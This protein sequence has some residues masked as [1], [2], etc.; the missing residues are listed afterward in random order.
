VAKPSK[1]TEGATLEAVLSRSKPQIERERGRERQKERERERESHRSRGRG[2]ERQRETG[3][4][5][6]GGRK[7]KDPKV[8]KPS[9]RTEG[10]TLEAV[11]SRSKPQT[12]FCHGPNPKSL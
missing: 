10:A 3:I 4:E 6:Q 5:K 1:H 8:A 9:K 2:R 11:L 12:L 7:G